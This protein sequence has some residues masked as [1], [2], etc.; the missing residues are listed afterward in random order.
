MAEK[1]QT[2]AALDLL[3][4]PAETTPTEPRYR[5]GAVAR[6]LRM[7]V[8]TLR[9]WER[10]YRVAQS[11]L[12]ARGQRLYA[13]ADVQ[14]LLL[15]KQLCERGH[16]IGS[17]APLDAA[18]LRAVAATHA[19]TVAQQAVAV[20]A[21]GTAPT[22]AGASHTVP[23]RRWDDHALTEFAGLSS[24]IACECPAH[25][26]ELLRQLSRFEDYSAQ[27]Q[28]ISQAAK[29]ADAELHAHLRHV[30]GAARASFERALERIA[31]QEGLLLPAGP[32]SMPPSV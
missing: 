19:R 11:Q 10:R 26:A 14:R 5:S 24:T 32:P 2:P 3:Q 8:A 9:V 21:I 17:L 25:V 23:A 29:P 27:C 4:A 1:K 15:I 12:S 13:A 18:Q 7:P 22:E 30:A 28:A 31:L 16:A 6:M 20:S